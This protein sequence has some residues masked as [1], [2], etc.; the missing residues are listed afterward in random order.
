MSHCDHGTCEHTLKH[1]GHCDVAYCTAC[2]REWGH[3][4]YRW[5]YY[6]YWTTYTSPT[7]SA[8]SGNLGTLT[9]SANVMC[10]HN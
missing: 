4:T 5:P 2:K 6:P 1:C 8:G 9:G 3:H 7:G 10:E